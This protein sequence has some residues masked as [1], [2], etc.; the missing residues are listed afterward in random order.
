MIQAGTHGVTIIQTGA[1]GVITTRLQHP[2]TMGITGVIGGVVVSNRVVISARVMVS[3]RVVAS[4]VVVVNNRVAIS[5]R[6]MAS[7]R[8]VVSAGSW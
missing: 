8:V 6:V 2:I 7:N 3:N 4:A 1:R 5:A